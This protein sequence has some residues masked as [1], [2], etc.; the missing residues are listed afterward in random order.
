MDQCAVHALEG[1]K[2]HTLVMV[3]KLRG[4]SGTYIYIYMCV[5]VCACVCVC[6]SERGRRLEA[7]AER[8]EVEEKLNELRE[9]CCTHF[10]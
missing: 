8:Q 6:V 9:V 10:L 7:E 5:C 3:P 2:K 4:P 1:H